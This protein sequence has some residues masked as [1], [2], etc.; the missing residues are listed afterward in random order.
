MNK[1]LLYSKGKSAQRSAKTCMGKITKK[2]ITTRI[3]ESGYCTPTTNTTL[4]IN[5]IPTYHT[6]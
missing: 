4:K 2:D 5:Y 3:N 1:Y 6:C